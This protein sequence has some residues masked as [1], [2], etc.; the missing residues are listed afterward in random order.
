MDVLAN[1]I[2]QKIKLSCNNI[3]FVSNTKGFIKFIFSFTSDWDNLIKI[4]QFSQNGVC[5]ESCLDSNDSV[6]LPQE[7]KEGEFKLSL[8]AEGESMLAR[9]FPVILMLE[10]SVISD[11]NKIKA[12]Y[13]ILTNK[14]SSTISNPIVN[15]SISYSSEQT[16]DEG[17]IVT[18]NFLSW[19]DDKKTL[20]NGVQLTA[21][22]RLN[23]GTWESIVL[24]K[25]NEVW[26]DTMPHSS[27]LT[28]S[29]KVRSAIAS[30]DF[31]I[32]RGGSDI[33]G[34]AG[35][36][37]DSYNPVKYSIKI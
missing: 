21:F 15:Y 23:D 25:N 2:G 6:S 22:A 13:R 37:G 32:S 14:I 7:L 34:I 1:V 30:L 19:L 10:K 35:S 31:F 5:Y 28:L 11:N 33:G 20:G 16:T 27:S 12:V 17:L 36:I 9:T 8:Y 3:K 29:P 24:K 26:K 18:L 4:A